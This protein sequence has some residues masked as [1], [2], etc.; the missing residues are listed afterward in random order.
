MGGGGG[1][2]LSKPSRKGVTMRNLEHAGTFPGI[3][4]TPNCIKK[5]TASRSIPH[6]NVLLNLPTAAVSTVLGLISEAQT[7]WP[8][9]LQS[10]S[11]NQLKASP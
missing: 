5:Q 2:V 4:G 1:I 7:Y 3:Y 6:H 11:L 10:I 9:R 8:D